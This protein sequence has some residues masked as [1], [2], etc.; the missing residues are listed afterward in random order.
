V[1]RQSYFK[2]FYTLLYALY[3]NRGV[4]V[5]ASNAQPIH[6][7]TSAAHNLTTGD[8]IVVKNVAGNTAANGTWIVT[9]ID[10]TTLTL[11]GSQGTGN[12][13]SGGS[14][15]QLPPA[16]T[17]AQYAANVV[18]FRDAD[19]VMTPFEYDV[20]PADGWDVDGDVRTNDGGNDRRVVF[21]AERPEI[22]I[23]KA[24]AWR[25][26]TTGTGGMVIALH[27]PWNALAYSSGNSLPAEPCDYALDTLV[28]SANPSLV[29]GTL[30]IPSNV[31]DLGKKAS[32]AIMLAGTN[33]S[34]NV[35]TDTNYPIW[36]LRIVSG[37]TARYVRFDT[38][39]PAQNSEYAPNVT[40]G[41][42][43]PRLSVDSTITCFSGTTI[44]LT[45]TSVTGTLTG[46]AFLGGVT[47]TQI[48]GMRV[49]G[50]TS[51]ATISLE[52]LSDPSQ[53]LTP[54]GTIPGTA[55]TG[56]DVWNSGAV[57]QRVTTGTT[58]VPVQYVI[59][60]SCTVRVIETSAAG[61]ALPTPSGTSTARLTT[62]PTAAFWKTGTFKD[63]GTIVATGTL[64]LSSTLSPG[65]TSWFPWP[66]RPFVSS[67]ELLLVPR[68]DSLGILENYSRPTPA[69]QSVVGIPVPLP[70]IFDAVNVPT[71]FAGNR[72]TY[73]RD[74]SADTGI[75]G[76]TNPANQ[77]SNFREPGRVNLNTVVSD[78]VWNAVVAGPLASPIASRTS[79][80]FTGTAVLSGTA[81]QSMITLLSLSATGTTVVSDTDPALVSATALNPLHAIYT[82]T[83]LANTVTTRSNLFAI[84]IT[85]RES[86][87]DDPDSVKYRRAFY[88][89]DRSLPVGYEEGKDHNV[90]DM[91]RLRRIIE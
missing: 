55:V 24:F 3:Q 80:G 54:A 59:V 60:D 68:F 11:D 19:S 53:A 77:L 34:F 4:V 18:E 40:S 36:R 1:Q 20:N 14:F 91:I 29:T 63:N 23:Q 48:A 26:S 9:V 51:V 56:S 35:V 39:Q 72:R 46:T 30:G 62:S 73:T 81:A 37:T 71:R 5:S 75:F 85:L 42:D 28:N 90:L 21:G 25:N 12:Y 83:R 78:D 82:A 2:D 58:L 38:N 84:W 49:T 64:T 44:L 22:L 69:N 65:Q 15:E 8:T 50:T 16:P 17:L 45:A 76:I 27:R 47:G 74:H 86:T 13:T 41:A 32:S 33:Q 43:K 31:V 70:L 61:P 67:A 52:R 79:A 88:I 7:V 66:N 6:I 89:V 87:A 57:D 10:S